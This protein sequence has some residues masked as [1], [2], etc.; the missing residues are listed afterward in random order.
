M[1]R[2]MF[3]LE[4]LAKIKNAKEDVAILDFF[5]VLDSA[6]GNEK[7]DV[8]RARLDFSWLRN[9]AIEPFPAT[10]IIR[11]NFPQRVGDYLKVPKVV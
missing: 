3:S 11:Q 9:D 5:D 10:E 4:Q 1:Y 6:I 8:K 2:E 7:L